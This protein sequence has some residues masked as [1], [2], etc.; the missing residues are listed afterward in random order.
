MTSRRNIIILSGLAVL[1]MGADG[2]GCQSTENPVEQSQEREREERGDLPGQRA[3][4]VVSV[5]SIETPYYITVTRQNFDGQHIEVYNRRHHEE[6]VGFTVDYRT[7]DRTLAVV[8]SK[9]DASNKNVMT[10]ALR[11][12]EYEF[13]ADEQV[14]TNPDEVVCVWIGMVGNRPEA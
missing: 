12:L 4:M 13:P 2:A 14:G 11:R 9:H 5:A 7:D 8:A 3:V 10:C 6:A 1:A